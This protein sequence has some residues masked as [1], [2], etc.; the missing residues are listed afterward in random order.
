M[1]GQPLAGNLNQ[2]AELKKKQP[3]A[4]G[5]DLA[6]RLDLSKYFSDAVR[7]RRQSRTKLVDSCVDLWLKGNLPGLRA[8]RRGR[9]L[10]RHRPGLGVARLGGQRRQR[11]PAR[12][13]AELHRAAA[14]SS[15]QQLDALGRQTK[16]R[17][18]LTAFLPAAPA[19]IDAGFEAEKI[20]KYLDFGTVQGYDFHGSWEPGPTSS[21][22]C[23]CRPGRAGQPGLL[24]RDRR[25]TP[26]SRRGAP[27]DQLVLGIP[28]YGQGW[29]GV[30]GGDGLFGTATG[31]APGVFA[32]GTEDYKTLKNLPA[33]GFKV[34]RDLRAGHT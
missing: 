27:R 23:G 14:P 33:Q 24:D 10:R 6:R 9:H 30:T 18:E 22:R 15:G 31:P 2:L 28:Y 5:A 1:A 4:A 17:Y 26:G 16:H 8:G 3:E 20:F 32:A 11:D 34:H 13:Q 29:T 21:R 7:H 12:G 19:K 25:S